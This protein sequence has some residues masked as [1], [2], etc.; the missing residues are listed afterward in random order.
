[1]ET[2]FDQYVPLIL[3]GTAGLLVG[4]AVIVTCGL[5]GVSRLEGGTKLYSGT[6]LAEGLHSL[7]VNAARTVPL[8]LAIAFLYTLSS[9]L[10]AAFRAPLGIVDMLTGAGAIYLGHRFLLEK[11]LQETGQVM[12][13]RGYAGVLVRSI[14][15]S[16]VLLLLLLVLAIPY[17]FVDAL[18]QNTGAAMGLPDVALGFLLGLGLALISIV[19]SRLT[20][21]FPAAS[22]GRRTW[23]ATAAQESHGAGWALAGALW[24]NFLIMLVVTVIIVSGLGVLHAALGLPVSPS[25]EVVPL[26]DP[27]FVPGFLFIELP[28][29][30]MMTIYML[31]AI[32]I[33]SAAYRRLVMD[34]LRT[35]TRTD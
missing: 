1:M 17:L 6:L 27:A 7:K 21:T 3:G 25:M 28:M 16:L 30:L 23:L 18:L 26:D 32:S 29:I 13:K 24:S 35:E 33:V 22:L 5:A 11:P 31:A 19:M 14:L 10:T 20:F 34:P 9:L 15:I 12:E 2:S 4:V 8:F